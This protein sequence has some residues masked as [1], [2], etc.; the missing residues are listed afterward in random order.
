MTSKI[1]AASRLQ[2]RGASY[3]EYGLLLFAIIIAGAAAVRKIGPKIASAGSETTAALTGEGGAGG[4]AGGGASEPP[5]SPAGQAILQGMQQAQAERAAGAGG[6]TQVA[7][8]GPGQAYYEVQ[9]RTGPSGSWTGTGR[10]Q[11]APFGN[12]AISTGTGIRLVPI[13]QG[14]PPQK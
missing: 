8:L 9:T 13:G 14:N 3:V 12:S 6:G 11:V 1:H 4:G 10:I 5:L 2:V 7:Q